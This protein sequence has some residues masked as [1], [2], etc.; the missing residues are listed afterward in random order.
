MLL[1]KRKSEQTD[2]FVSSVI[3]AEFYCYFLNKRTAEQNFTAISIYAGILLKMPM[4]KRTAEQSF[5]AILQSF[6]AISQCFTAISLY[7]GILMKMPLN[8]RS[9]EQ[10]EG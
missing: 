7:A 2:E 3:Q 10:N 5:T 4:N 8:K 9:A 1:N 6:T